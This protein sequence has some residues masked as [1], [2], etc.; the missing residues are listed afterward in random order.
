[1]YKS[2]SNI[3]SYLLQISHAST[4]EVLSNKFKFPTF[5]RTVPSDKYQTM[6]IAELV[7]QFN[8]KTVAIIGSNDEYGKLGAESLQKLFQGNACID[9]ITILPS[10][11]FQND[12]NTRRCLNEVVNNISISTAEVIIMFTREIN[13]II[14]MEEAKKQKL[15]RTW[16]ASDTWSTLTSLYE[17][18]DIELAG[19]VFGIIY[20]R[21]EVPGFKDYVK[22]NFSGVTNPFLDHYYNNCTAQPETSSCESQSGLCL[23]SSCLA[24]YIDQDE[25]YLLYL[26]V[27]VIVEG[28]RSLCNK[29]LCGGSAKFTALEVQ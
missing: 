2:K 22:S 18:P 3:F 15:N 1:M 4:S 10:E 21:N 29:E 8:W 9:Y 28:I 17:T 20:K 16:I 11:F 7:K 6:A 5:L 26:A 13:A 23:N 25:S 27:Q 24:Q 14:I 19:Q 12:S